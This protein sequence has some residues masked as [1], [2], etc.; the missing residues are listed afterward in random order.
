MS[1]LG[2]YLSWFTPMTY[3]GVSSLAGADMTTFL[4]PFLRCLPAVS[5]VRLMPVASTM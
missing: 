2:E 3:V 1:S 5:L 4:A